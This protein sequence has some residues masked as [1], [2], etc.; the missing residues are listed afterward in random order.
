V[1]LL[2]N[3]RLAPLEGFRFDLPKDLPK[4]LPKEVPF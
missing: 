4:Y 2:K 3:L 1:P